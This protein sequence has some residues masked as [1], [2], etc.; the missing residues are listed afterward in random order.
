MS[1]LHLNWCG[2]SISSISQTS[3]RRSQQC[4]MTCI[5]LLYTT[6]FILTM[7][8]ILHIVQS[9]FC[10][11]IDSIFESNNNIEEPIEREDEAQVIEINS[12]EDG[13]TCHYRINKAYLSSILV[14]DVLLWGYIVL[15]ISRARTAIRQHHFI[16]G[17]QVEDYF[18]SCCCNCCTLTQLA[19]EVSYEDHET[20]RLSNVD[21]SIGEPGD[22]LNESSREGQHCYRPIV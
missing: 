7:L 9:I 19:K 16:Y 2:K 5:G 1:K 21:V 3:Q 4:T 12:L 14:L 17:G 6:A 15:L 10:I 20:R 22:F 8:L 18:V 11:E 13:K